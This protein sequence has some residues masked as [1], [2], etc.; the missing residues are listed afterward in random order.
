MT[1]S[2]MYFFQFLFWV[3]LKMAGI[4][5]VLKLIEQNAYDS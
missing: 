2:V 1:P 3:S 5:N 4:K